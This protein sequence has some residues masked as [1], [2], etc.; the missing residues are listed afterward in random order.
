MP[1]TDLHALAV[2]R[3]L[4][5]VG[6]TR[7]S[8]REQRR[9][10]R[11]PM[12]A[13]RPAKDA[14][15]AVL[16]SQA[17]AIE[18]MQLIG[19]RPGAAPS[20]PIASLLEYAQANALRFDLV[21]AAR[22]VKMPPLPVFN[23]DSPQGY[24]ATT[25]TV[26]SCVLGDAVVSS[27][28][29]VILAGGRALIDF[30][31]DEL[32]RVPI[33]LAVDSILFAPTDGHATFAVEAGAIDDPPLDE[34][35]A[36]VGV[37]SFNYWHWQVEFLPR[38]LACMEL[39]GFEGVPILVDAQMPA[40]AMVALRFLIGD[41]HPVRALGPGEAVRVAQ[42]WTGAMFTYMP[43]WPA[44]GVA[45]PP[46]T[47]VMDAEALVAQLARMEPLLQPLGTGRGPRRLYLARAQSQ[48][49]GMVNKPEVD[50]WFAANGFEIVDFGAVPYEDQLRM[51]RD[52]DIIVGPNGAAMVN[53]LFAGSDTSIG[54]L[55][56]KFIED[57]EWYAAV[58]AGLGQRLSFLVGETVNADP[59]H[60]FNAN[61][62]I[63]TAILPAF[64]AGLAAPH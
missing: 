25:R 42:L 8:L 18:Y 60:E 59:V 36:L 12:G 17:A 26:F 32:Q 63:D 11:P 31:D 20:L 54:I 27:K 39:P 61:Y 14:L 5:S 22:P 13:L 55:D 45:Y 4:A 2:D 49:R 9:G 53:S 30:Q 7:E 37:N 28:S 40:Q 44:A 46:R 21:S 51:V 33:D 58:S 15:T 19:N 16:G 23:D 38:L 56:N 48:H 10:P 64:L 43:L 29:N 47:M 34:A 3:A 57:N 50:A 41:R 35:L 1:A 6:F 52:A 24:Q 62:R